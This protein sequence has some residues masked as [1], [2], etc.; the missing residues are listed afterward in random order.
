MGGWVSEWVG[1]SGGGSGGGGGGRIV[2]ST[3][4][5]TVPLWTEKITP[6]ISVHN[7]IFG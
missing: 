4:F 5:F 7:M 3:G 2:K 1:G 6:R